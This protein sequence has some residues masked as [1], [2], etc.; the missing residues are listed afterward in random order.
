MLSVEFIIKIII[1]LIFRDILEYAVDKCL[2]YYST[3]EG[4]RRRR[5]Q[6]RQ[7]S[8]VIRGGGDGG[9]HEGTI[10]Q[11]DHRGLVNTRVCT[12][13]AVTMRLYDI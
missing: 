11:R 13:K 12:S 9:Y 3:V 1:K 8:V 4:K 2:Q 7:L 10:G 6:T 5:G